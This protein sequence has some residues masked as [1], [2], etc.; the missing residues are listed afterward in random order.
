MR[1]PTNDEDG[2]AQPEVSQVQ[3][4]GDCPGLQQLR[5]ERMGR[6]EQPRMHWMPGQRISADPLRISRNLYT[7][8]KLRWVE[9]LLF[10]SVGITFGIAFTNTLSFHMTRDHVVYVTTGLIVFMALC[11]C[12]Y[13]YRGNKRLKA[14]KRELDAMNE[15]FSKR[16]GM[17][18]ED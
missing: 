16:Y 6:G 13:V 3:G 9:R 12:V 11:Q 5:R 7:L 2:K 18:D 8:E 17:T 15:D 4:E 1:M 10:I 14:N